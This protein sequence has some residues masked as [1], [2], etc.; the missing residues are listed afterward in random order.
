MI[1]ISVLIPVYNSGELLVKCL[2]S[3]LGQVVAPDEILIYDDCP[4]FPSSDLIKNYKSPLL[5]YHLNN[6]N[7]GRTKNYKSLLDNASSD[8]VLILDG[9]DQLCNRNFISDAKNILKDNTYIAFSGGCVNNYHDINVV[10][11]LSEYSKPING[12]KYFK[13]WIS[14]KQ[15]L[16]H[17]STIFKRDIAVKLNCYTK[18]IIN[19]DILSQRILLLHGELYLSS[20]IY[21]QWNYTGFNSSSITSVIDF[22]DNFDTINTPFISA[23]SRYGCTISLL[24]WFFLS[25]IKYIGG[26]TKILLKTNTVNL[27]LFYWQI[28]SK[29]RSLAITVIVLM[30]TILTI[31]ILFLR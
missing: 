1:T 19:T 3:V 12:Y 25:T 4:E 23:L 13:K 2:D 9:D 6:T 28:I 26:V 10:R 30:A 29:Y 18:D 21:S 7:I 27:L 31:S 15:T 5:K 16:P 17:S 20:E 11:T 22:A 8:Y 24:I 14:A